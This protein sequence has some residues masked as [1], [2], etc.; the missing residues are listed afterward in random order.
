MTCPLRSVPSL[1]RRNAPSW[2]TFLFLLPNLFVMPCALAGDVL[3]RADGRQTLGQLKS[4]EM[5]AMEFQTESA[6]TVERVP[7]DQMIRYGHAVAPEGAANVWLVDG[8]RLAATEIDFDQAA[9]QVSNGWAHLTIP[10]E[11]VRAIQ[12]NGPLEPQQL[13]RLEQTINTL[14]GADDVLRMLDGSMQRGTLRL[15]AT[16][17]GAG[18]GDPLVLEVE[19]QR[20]QVP[21]EQVRLFVPSPILRKPSAGFLGSGVMVGLTDG[22]LLR[23]VDV[24]QAGG[25]R[26]AC[27]LLIELRNNFSVPQQIVMLAPGRPPAGLLAR[28]EPLRYRHVSMFGQTTPL[29]RWSSGLPQVWRNGIGFP[30]GLQ[31]GMSSR[32][33][34]KLD[35]QAR[36]TGTVAVFDVTQATAGSLVRP[37]C[38]FRVQTADAQGNVTTR[39]QSESLLAGE[40]E[41]LNVDV[42]GGSLLILGTDSVAGGDLGQAVWRDAGLVATP[43]P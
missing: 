41:S 29:R 7:L 17:H 27:G 30:N 23:V 34:Y 5:S 40:S 14:G 20:L 4:F 22:S 13:Q 2:W 26:L 25:W 43:V 16:V 24:G 3:V 31:V 6:S 10:L 33:V 39:W 1:A 37:A 18:K 42:S 11:W 36:L 9:C 38:R 28:S 35:G 12:W 21:V 32:L 19:R 15:E 8:S